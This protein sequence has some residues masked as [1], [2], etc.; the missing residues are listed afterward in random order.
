MTSVTEDEDHRE[1]G[2]YLLL[3]SIFLIAICA[4]IYELIAGAV[5]SYLLGSSVTHFSLVIGL[6]L[7]AMGLGAYLTRF[8]TDRLLERFVQIELIIGLVGGSS[9]LLLFSTFTYAPHAYMGVMISVA[10]VVGALVGME[11]PLIIRVLEERHSALKLTIA[12][13]MAVDYLG[14]LAASLAFPFILVPRLGLMR[15]SFLF[16][17]L[18]LAVAW[19]GIYRFWP[20]LRSRRLN[21]SLA[22]LISLLLT[23]GLVRSGELVSA[24]EARVFPDQ[25]ILS[26]D[27]NFQRVIVT[28]WRE[29]IRLYLNGA[30]QFSS[31]DEHRYHEALVHPAMRRASSH[32]DILILGGGDGFAVREVLKY[33]DVKR[34][35]LVDIDPV[36]TDL[37]SDH[38]AL[39]QLNQGSLTHPKVHVTNQDAALFLGES[40]RAWDVMIMD[41]PD[42]ESYEIGRLYTL[43]Q[44]SIL[45]QHL[46][47]RGVIVV[48][49]TS[50][51]YAREAFW[52]IAETL[53]QTPSLRAGELG[54]L[55]IAPYHLNVPSFGEWGF[56]LA[57]HERETLSQTRHPL[58]NTRFL[59]PDTENTLFVFPNDLKRP[60]EIEINQL[61]TQR[62]VRYYTTSYRQFYGDHH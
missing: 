40:E 53:N 5:S 49:S 1:A 56:V 2:D 41:L 39:N 22:C 37:F 27:T 4:L 62:L 29:D 46:R 61:N 47:P 59:N 44:L 48:Q 50:P 8:F 31:V 33:S 38:P 51:F 10:S 52:C 20:I 7:S 14:A 60:E 58:P 34:I 25:I 45:S 13:V 57:S 35:D 6:F 3:F 18:N 17:L 55:E 9:A 32:Q 16:G 21:L 30:L 12:N 42:P 23:L 26:R 43:E 24:I 36:V 54:T 11:L 19:V 15:T 28:N